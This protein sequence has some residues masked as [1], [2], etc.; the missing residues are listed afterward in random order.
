[1][2]IY[3]GNLSRDVTEDELKGL[4]SKY[5]GVK[6]VKIIK[7]QY[8]GES[9]GFGFLEMSNSSEA[10]K[11]ISELNSKELKGKKLTVNEAR[12]REDKRGGG[13]RDRR[14]GGGRERSW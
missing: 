10:Q 3:V 2:N 9:K 6:D 14:G 7:D 4:F 11:A 8:S 1:M 13:G 5:G 12:P